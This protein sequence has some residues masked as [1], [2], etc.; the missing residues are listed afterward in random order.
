[1]FFRLW[2]EG[3]EEYNPWKAFDYVLDCLENG[4]THSSKH[5]ISYGVKADV[6]EKR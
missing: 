2:L 5:E 3:I 1:M 4:K 6:F